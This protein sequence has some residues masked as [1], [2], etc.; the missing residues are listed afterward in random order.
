[1]EYAAKNNPISPSMQL[2]KYMQK[3]RRRRKCQRRFSHSFFFL[4]PEKENRYREKD[5]IR[6]EI[7]YNKKKKMTEKRISKEKI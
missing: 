4:H 1:M 6:T 7:Q 3:R 2:L 5:S